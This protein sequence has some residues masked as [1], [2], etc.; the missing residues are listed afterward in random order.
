MVKRAFTESPILQHFDVEKPI[1]LQTDAN[2]F[3]MAEILNQFDNLGV[4]RPTTIYPRKCTPRQAKYDTYDRELL[5]I[6][7]S[8]KQWRHPREVF[9]VN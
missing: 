6:V 7:A 3:A 4:P 2:G 1:I 8:M 5:A 9:P